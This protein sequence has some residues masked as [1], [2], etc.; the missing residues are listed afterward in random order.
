[1]VT[2]SWQ[3]GDM[4]LI[5]LES[6]I[7]CPA[8]GHAKAESMPTDA[9]QWFYECE[10]C[11]RVL[12]PKQ[13]DCCVFLSYGTSKCPPRQ[14][15]GGSCCAYADVRRASELRMGL[16]GDPAAALTTGIEDRFRPELAC[17][18]ES[19]CQS[20]AARPTAADRKTATLP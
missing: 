12:R 7:T 9:C 6:T 1:M 4:A 8:C 16:P 20:I 19:S 3:F 17:P 14:S 5:E 2:P 13:G 11:K 18:G 10:H 15:G